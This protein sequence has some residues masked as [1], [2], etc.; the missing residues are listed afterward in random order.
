MRV[1]IAAA[2]T[3][4]HINPAIS[5]AN[6]IKEKEKDSEIVFLGT[7]RGLENDLVPRAGYEL[8]TINAYGLS[9]NLSLEN[10]KKMRKTIKGLFEAKKIVKEFKPDIVIGTGG[11]ICGAAVV[12]ANSYKIPVL[13]H[14]SNAFPGKAI[15]IASRKTDTILVSFKDAIPRI[16]KIGRAHV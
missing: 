3:A 15:K 11:Y 8:K 1:L 4:G 5:I 7:T 12:A 6:I 16:S 10:L 13:L 9:K 14:E 2:G